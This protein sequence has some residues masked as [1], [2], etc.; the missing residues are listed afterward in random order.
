M[1]PISLYEPRNAPLLNQYRLLVPRTR[2]ILEVIQFA[3]LLG[4]YLSFMA[5]RDPNIMS[6][7]EICFVIYAMGWV[8]DQFATILE[9][10]WYAFYRR[11]P[12]CLAD[13]VIGT[14]TRRTCARSCRPVL[15]RARVHCLR[16]SV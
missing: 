9:H 10:G 12:W 15:I 11:V 6:D 13:K 1:R 14:F 16:R 4:L 7:L 8:L 2:Y 3:I 5:E